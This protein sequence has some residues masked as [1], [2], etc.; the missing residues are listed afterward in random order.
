M[1]TRPYTAVLVNGPKTR[2][3]NI[4]ASMEKDN[5][6]RNIQEM[7][8]DEWVVALIPGEHANHAFSFDQEPKTNPSVFVSHIDLFD[9]SY[10]AKHDE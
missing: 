8:P 9:T 2:I 3:I 6:H 10:I 5:A 7:F 1:I 4:D